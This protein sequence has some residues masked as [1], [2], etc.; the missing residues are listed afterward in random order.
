MQADHT[1]TLLLVED[2]AIIALTEQRIL[3]RHGYVV[4]VA[5]SGEAAV[6]RV[7]DNPDVDL[8]LMDID[9]GPGI[10]GTEAS[11]RIL[12]LRNLPIVFLTSHTEPDYVDRVKQITGYGYVVKSSG[13]FVLLESIDMALKLWRT[14]QQSQQEKERYRLITE[15]MSETVLTVDRD[16]RVT[17]VS[18]SIER[19]TGFTPDE[20][21]RMPIDEVLTEDSARAVTEL[22]RRQEE[23]P[24]FASAPMEL[25][26]RCRNGTTVWT[27][28]TST[29]IFSE[30]GEVI[31]FVATIRDIGDRIRYRSIVENT[32]DA[33]IVHDFDGVVTFVN[34]AAARLL[35][36]DKRE[37]IGMHLDEFHAEPSRDRLLL[38]AEGRRWS[39]RVVIEQ[40]LIRSDGQRIPVEVSAGI[41]SREGAGE[42]HAFVRDVR[43]RHNMET[44]FRAVYDQTDESIGVFD[45]DGR[46]LHANRAAAWKLSLSPA[47]V[48]GR[49]LS[50]V[51]P[52]PFAGRAM[53]GIRKVFESGRSRHAEWKTVIDGRTKWFLVH[54]EPSVDTDGT[55]RSVTTF[56]TDI[57]GLKQTQEAYELIA[58]HAS[59]VVGVIDGEL[60]PIYLSPSAERLLG[61]G[62]QDFEGRSIFEVVHEDDVEMLKAALEDTIRD[63]TD[64]LRREFRILTASGDVIWTDLRATHLYDDRGGLDRIIITARDI[65]PRVELETRLRETTARLEA[66]LNAIPELVFEIDEQLRF[67]EYRRPDGRRLYLPPETFLGRSIDEVFPSGVANRVR[68]AVSE[69]SRTAPPVS[70]DYALPGDDGER[71]FRASVARHDRTTAGEPDSAGYVFVIHDVTDLVRA[72][73]ELHAALEHNRWLV[74]EV[75]HRVKN[76]LAIISSLIFLTEESLPE[77]VSLAN[78]RNQIEAVRF[79]HEQLQ[80]A[81]DEQAV[82]M[83]PYLQGLLSTVLESCA[84]GAVNL[85]VEARGV[86]L[87]GGQAVSAGLIANELATNACKHGFTADGERSFTVVLAEESG[88]YVFTAS[89]SGRP[90]PDDVDPYSAT[91]LGLQLVV[92]LAQQLGGELEITRGPRPV[93]TI[94]FPASA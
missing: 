46:F 64:D 26:R 28:T 84:T 43:G 59:D 81:S 11:R 90:F 74:R 58:E 87:P 80:Q 93:F 56:S 86:A 79:A 36:Y 47:E 27:E 69:V 8:I 78:L 52:E 51:Y 42:I 19:L 77:E 39:D 1:T 82:E 72:Q 13:E 21:R 94:R 25:E 18:P 17:Y 29:P 45:E 34:A 53:D 57:T 85:D 3:E 62:K 65:T 31:G 50:D 48:R 16:F 32:N 61:Y 7:R 76:N 70:V 91:T 63:R 71:F 66:T 67:R 41:A 54:L 37:L 4:A 89:N 15:N 23:D 75:H 22:A 68:E 92:N 24:A 20:Y 5:H 55:V 40:E 2:E 14:H 73:H 88:E 35:G 9:L 12:E 60:R 44:A 49:T 83:A 38:V 30:E 10:D 33:L 6:A